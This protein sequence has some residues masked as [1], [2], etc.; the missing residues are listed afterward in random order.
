MQWTASLT[1]KG[2]KYIN[3]R[4]TMVREAHLDKDVIVTHIPG[5]INSS[6]LFTKEIKSDAHFRRLRDSMMVSKA[7]F[8]KYN[9]NV[10]EHMTDKTT[11]PYYSIRAS[12]SP[13]ESCVERRVTFADDVQ[14]GD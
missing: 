13:E 2:I 6:D 14:G 5:V 7:N 3:L 8:L 9:H 12:G 1:S 11:L 10:P 4:E